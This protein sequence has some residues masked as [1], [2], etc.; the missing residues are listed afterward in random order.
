[1]AEFRGEVL[2]FTDDDMHLAPGWLAAYGNAMSTFPD[3]EYFGGRILPD[4]GNVKPRWIRDE[5]LPLLDGILNWFDYGIETRPYGPIDQGP[6][7]GSFGVKRR[8]FERVGG[9][10][11]D[12]GR[13]GAGLGR[14]EDTEF[15][16]RAKRIGAQGIYV[17]RSL[18]LHTI[19]QHRLGL[20]RL[21]RYGIASGRARQLVS[22]ETR[23][24]SLATMVSFLLRGVFQLIKGRGDRFRQCIINAGIE[25]GLMRFQASVD[26]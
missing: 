4:W 2:L 10:R 8:L 16:D 14:G 5:P 7:G 15:I 1:V 19:D 9:F 18:C 17:G 21:F 6:I 20:L 25:I 12:L 22:A 23:Y 11:S 3:A 13:V 24:G 26:R